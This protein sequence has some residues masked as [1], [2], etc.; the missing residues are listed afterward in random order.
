YL[1]NKQR[2]E[3]VLDELIFRDPVLKPPIWVNEGD[4]WGCYPLWS[5][6]GWARDRNGKVRSRL[7][8]FAS[9]QDRVLGDAARL[10]CGLLDGKAR[11]VTKNPDF[12]KSL[13]GWNFAGK[14]SRAIAWD[15]RE[16]HDGAG[17]LSGEGS[18]SISQEAPVSGGK[19]YT[20]LGFVKITGSKTKAGYLDVA[21]LDGSGDPID[22]HYRRK[23]LF[24]K[25]GVWTPI[26]TTI[27]LPALKRSFPATWKEP[28]TMKLLVNISG[29]DPGERAYI[30][31]CGIYVQDSEGSTSA[32][33]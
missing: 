1:A 4:R 24:L 10:M 32:R 6:Y 19:K 28:A 12:S 20:C 14:D 17:A 13:D 3:D 33:P 25:P 22:Q 26:A 15:G 23:T 21:I 9:S 5:L 30:D 29:L 8:Q 2:R 11:P 27:D 16:G 18:W 31:D 7:N